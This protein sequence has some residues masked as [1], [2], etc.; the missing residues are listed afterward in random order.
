[1]RVPRLLTRME[2]TREERWRAIAA[3][4]RGSEVRPEAVP[5]LV[6]HVV[7]EHGRDLE[8]LWN[9]NVGNVKYWGNRRE[10]YVLTDRVGDTDKYRSHPTLEAGVRPYVFEIRRR[11]TVYEAAK[12]GDVEAFAEG[13]LATGYIGRNPKWTRE[14]QLR[15]LT[16]DLRKL[17]DEVKQ[18]VG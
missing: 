15:R 16:A 4:L 14:E 13:L 12:A 3:A 5:L 11:F 7:L 9:W 6:A 1:M 10:H 8:G 2:G 17:Y 18:G